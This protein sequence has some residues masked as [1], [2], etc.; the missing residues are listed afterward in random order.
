MTFDFISI[1]T[2]IFLI[3]Y[4]FKITQFKLEANIVPTFTFLKCKTV[5]NKGD[6]H[7]N[8]S[9]ETLFFLKVPSWLLL[10]YK[11]IILMNAINLIDVT[12]IQYAWCACFLLHN[13]FTTS[14]MACILLVTELAWFW[15]FF[16]NIQIFGFLNKST[17]WMIP[18]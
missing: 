8:L 6:L 3:K 5:I 13:G 9:Q 11:H 14:L 17:Y 10:L 4:Y 15:K 1:A 16:S 7:N 2:S 18:I 12:M